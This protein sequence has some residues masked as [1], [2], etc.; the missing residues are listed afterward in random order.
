[1]KRYILYF[2]LL[3]GFLFNYSCTKDFEELNEE[4][5]LPTQTG[6]GPLF[7]GLVN[8]LV[9]GGNEQFY[10]SNEVLYKQTQQAALT[11][12]AWGNLSIGTEDIWSNYYR[13]LVHA[14]QIDIEIAKME[15]DPNIV[16]DEPTKNNIMAM[17]KTLMAYKTFKV[18]DLFGDMPFSDAGYGF[19]SLEYLRPKFDTQEEIYKNLLNELKWV[20]DNIVDSAN[21]SLVF[22]GFVVYDNLL[23][24]DLEMWRK[25][26]NSLRLRH[27]MRMADKDIEFAG[28]IIQDI[29]ENERPVIDGYDFITQKLESV[30]L[31]PFENN[32]TNGSVNWS[33]R[34]HNNL[35]MGSNV[36]HQ[37]AEHDSIDGS[38]IFDPRGYMFFEPDYDNEWKAFPQLPEINTPTSGGTPY[39]SHRDSPGNFG[40]KGQDCIYS[41]FNYFLIRDEDVV[42]IILITG[43]EVHFIKAEAYF[44]GIGVPLDQNKADEEYMNGITASIEW[45]NIVME[46]SFLP[47]SGLQFPDMNPI[48]GNLNVASVLNHFGSWMA[49]DDEQ[50]LEFIYT[51]RW[52]D[53]FRQPWEAYALA[54]RT[55]KTPREG[56]PI[57]HYRLPYPPSEAEYNSENYMDALNRQGGETSDVKIW[58]IP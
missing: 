58:W 33:F 55:G 7:N 39:A 42:P 5:A 56:D 19:Q 35:R 8:S 18:T 20:D 22:K 1:M 15:S 43:A 37:I 13:A 38:G 26:A 17:V 36:W 6:I 11:R 40:L 16:L 41:P 54:R 14:R 48:P 3:T 49:E 47:T 25:M 52:L 44:R 12:E 9:L 23:F 51:Q 21:T 2:L 29:I 32:F 24:G 31:F 46:N 27:A 10:V 50:K 57:G 53:A 30:S 34:E 45:W 4:W 28:P